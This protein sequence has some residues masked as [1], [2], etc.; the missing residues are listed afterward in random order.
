MSVY[1]FYGEEEYFLQNKVKKIKKEFGELIKGIN[2]ISLDETNINSL[3]SDLETPAFGYDKK[4]II[5]KDTGL[6]KKEKRT[7]K[8]SN[9][10]T[11]KN[12]TKN[13]GE[14]GKSLVE[15]I[16]NYIKENIDTINNSVEL[17]FIEKE[18]EKN[19][20]Y[21]NI[22]KLGEVTNFE[23][24]KLPQLVSNIEKISKAYNVEIDDNT[25]K[26]LVEC[27]GS[28]MQE[29]INE[30]R[31][32][33]EYAG[34]GGKITKTS[35][36]ELCIKQ[37]QAI[38]FDLTDYLGE[39]NIAKALD[40]LK[41]LEYN[42]EP[43]QKI[44]ITLY[45]HF[46]KLYIVKIS[47]EYGT[48][49]AESMNLKPNQLFLTRKYSEQAKYFSKQELRNIMQGLVNLDAGYKQGLIDL[50]IGLDS[51]LCRYCSK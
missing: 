7:S 2:Y 27:C 6:F 17:I 50:D 48:N 15:K 34:N 13:S 49:L 20:L 29:L 30:L 10:E 8:T 18:P 35:I 24:L 44:L 28:G 22:E 46:K 38:I 51:I 45:N 23:L 41:K 33:I 36:D 16:A 21:E 19:I 3:I 25:A 4:L 40:I 31:K 47:Q 42:K 37:I 5:A 39:K 1:L 12:R 11:T 26:Y 9:K 14:T 43:V 32:V